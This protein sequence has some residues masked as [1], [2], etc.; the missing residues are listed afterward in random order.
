MEAIALDTNGGPDVL[1]RVTL[2]DP[3]PGPGEVL[4]RVAYA[5]VNY[6]EAEHRRGVFGPAEGWEVPGLEASGQIAAIGP[7]VD[8]FRIGQPVAAYL[9]RFG[10]YAEFVAADATFV[11]PLPDELDLATAG[12]F[13]CVAPTAY[14]VVAAAGRVAPGETVLIHAAAGGVGSLAVQIARALGAKQ[15]LGTVGNPAKIAYAQSLGYDVVLPRAGFAAEVLA[16]TGRRGVDVVLDPVGGPVREQSIPLLA[17][18]GRLVAFGDAA[19][20]ADLSLPLLSLW[21]NNRTA[22]GYNIGDLSRRAPE[23]WREHARAVLDLIARGAV[24]L[25]VA[26]V[27]PWGGV[28][29]V[30]KRL[31]TGTTTGK[32]VLHVADL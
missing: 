10:G 12:G 29:D 21:K 30:H 2:A 17:P 15:I 26:E 13:G 28:R 8:G 22:G 25:D 3:E 18:F 11:L 16:A 14:G 27:V 23:L 31:D 7:G 6:A 5:G 19:G 4:I 20:A 24:R 9:P 32:I 1:R